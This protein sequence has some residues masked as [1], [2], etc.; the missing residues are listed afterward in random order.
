M[1]KL[2]KVH[3]RIGAFTRSVSRLSPNWLP[4]LAIDEVNPSDGLRAAL[5]TTAM[6]L[7]GR[8]FHNPMFAWAAIGAF[9]TCLAD[10]AGTPRR[11]FFSMIF[12]AIFSTVFGGIT[13]YA[14]ATSI[15]SAAVAILI[16]SSAA[17]LACTWTAPVYQVAIL[18]ATACVVMADHPLHTIYDAASLLEIYFG[19]CL[20]A[21]LL[22]FTCW[23][24]LPH[25]QSR[26]A[27]R[28][29]YFRLADLARDNARIV[30]NAEFN[31]YEWEEHTVRLWTQLRIAIEIARKIL[32][33]IPQSN[34]EER[35]V[36][37]NHSLA[38]A[39][40]ERIFTCMVASGNVGESAH[41]GVF[42]VIRSA[43]CL[44]G[45]AEILRRMGKD[46]GRTSLS[47]PHALYQRLPTFA[48]RLERA[49]Q[50]QCWS[51]V[52]T[53]VTKDFI[54]ERELCSTLHTTQNTWRKSIASLGDFGWRHSARLGAA[55]TAIFLI[56]RTL[57]VPY[58][59]WGPMATLLILQPS[60]AA[61][62]PRTC[63]RAIGSTIGAVVAAAIGYLIHAPILISAMVFLMAYLTM[64][65][66][67]V[68]YAIFV[69]FLT[70]TFVLIADFSNPAY[71]LTYPVARLGSN[72]L[73]CLIA[74]LATYF[75]WPKRQAHNFDTTLNEAIRANL[76]YF[77]AALQFN[78]M[79]FAKCESMR[80]SAGLASNRAEEVYKAMRL[81]RL[82]CTEHEK[83]ALATLKLLRRVVGTATRI[84]VAG[85]GKEIDAE[86][87][88]WVFGVSRKINE[89]LCGGP[90]MARPEP[91]QSSHLRSIEVD[92]VNQLTQIW[93]SLY[94]M[95]RDG[96]ASGN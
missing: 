52:I 15:F 77:L 73:G 39:S 20:F 69:I 1:L 68:S 18:I 41:L 85:N 28:A 70:P 24:I 14:S 76:A 94:V 33:D 65:L 19:G 34:E 60:I 66:R 32:S 82:T 23:R 38:L 44:T 53:P 5:S 61:T 78:A 50:R 54:D 87:M 96:V 93:S 67:R 12:F 80:R 79:D 74:L 55:T 75:L 30:K 71:E 72:V 27:I 46:F 92:A 37:E 8:A 2:Y 63:E 84:R 95:R 7:V 86:L 10:A 45:I 90:L 89:H 47:F 83:G 22:S 43:R 62:W 6:L 58:G 21:I 4:S 88:V 9:W 51:S 49:M 25:A 42:K 40:A 3:L 59:Y 36:F 81:E 16:F 57:D 35:Q 31:S 91:F 56:V 29:V 11:R 48:K 17:G 26:H 13:I 64:T